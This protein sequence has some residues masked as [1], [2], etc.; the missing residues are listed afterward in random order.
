LSLYARYVVVNSIKAYSE[1]KLSL[2][3]KMKK[4]YVNK[5]TTNLC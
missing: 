2:H 3:N 1:Q 5:K 4:K